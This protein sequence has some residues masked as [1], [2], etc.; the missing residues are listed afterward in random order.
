MYID[1]SQS[2]LGHEGLAEDSTWVRQ[3]ELRGDR[4]A[5]AESVERETSEGQ[6]S[7]AC[8]VAARGYSDCFTS[9][10]RR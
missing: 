3:G 6:T 7:T 4:I 2:P 8:A 9:E 5:Y 10:R 1:A